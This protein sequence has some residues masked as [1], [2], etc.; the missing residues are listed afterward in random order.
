[1][2]VTEIEKITSLEQF[3][4]KVLDKSAGPVVLDLYVTWCAPSNAIAPRVAQFME[5]YPKA[6][7]YRVNV[8]AVPDV[9]EKVGVQAMPTFVFYNNG[10]KVQQDVVG[11]NVSMLEKAINSLIGST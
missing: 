7:F 8:S 9:A 2:S 1:M 3:Q 6:K 10:E 11:A 4:E 5:S